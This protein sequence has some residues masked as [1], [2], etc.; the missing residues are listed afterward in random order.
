MLNPHSLK[1]HVFKPVSFRTTR[2]WCHPVFHCR[3]PTNAPWR[4]TFCLVLTMSSIRPFRS[5]PYALPSGKATVI[6]SDSCSL[7]LCRGQHFIKDKLITPGMCLL[8]QI[9][10]HYWLLNPQVL[11]EKHQRPFSLFA[12]HKQINPNK[13]TTQLLYLVMRW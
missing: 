9:Q 7:L 10:A 4:K 13:R 6:V 5:Q 8:R 3:S 1:L 2:Y 12:A 11:G